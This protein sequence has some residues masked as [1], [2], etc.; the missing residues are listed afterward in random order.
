MDRTAE[1]AGDGNGSVE[2]AAWLRQVD[3][4]VEGSI[5]L[6]LFDLSDCLLRDWFDSDIEPEEAAE[7][8]IEEGF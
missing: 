6:S 7:M 5:G 3:A 8:A 1:Y 2:F 4:C